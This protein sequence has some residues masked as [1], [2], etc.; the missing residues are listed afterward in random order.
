MVY[1][2]LT[3]IDEVIGNSTLIEKRHIDGLEYIQAVSLQCII[4]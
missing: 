4:N 1:R 2:A 3:E